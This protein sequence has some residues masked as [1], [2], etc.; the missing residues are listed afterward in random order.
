MP[1][2]S[3]YSRDPSDPVVRAYKAFMGSVAKQLGASSK[4]RDFVQQT[5]AFEKR[6]AQ[7]HVAAGSDVRSSPKA[8]YNNVTIEELQIIANKA[9]TM[10]YRAVMQRRLPPVGGRQPLGRFNML[11]IRN[12]SSSI[13]TNYQYQLSSMLGCAQLLIG[14]LCFVLQC[15]AN[16]SNN[17][18]SIGIWGGIIFFI[19]GVLCI[20]AGSA[21]TSC[22]IVSVNA[23]S[24]V[25]ILFAIILMKSVSHEVSSHK[26]GVQEVH[27]VL[28]IVGAVERIAAFTTTL[29]ACSSMCRHHAS[30]SGVVIAPP[31]TGVVGVN[32]DTMTIAP[33][34]PLGQMPVGVPYP[35]QQPAMPA[36]GAPPPGFQPQY[37]P[38]PAPMVST[39]PPP[40][41]TALPADPPPA[42]TAAVPSAPPA[43]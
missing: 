20:W 16:V 34:L 11:L 13:R 21:K 9:V 4:V 8:M 22:L 7:L 30:S 12:E 6:L 3:Y 41:Y 17:V 26:Q 39:K 29:I 35:D 33:V 27:I 31:T 38:Q 25:S 2:K 10:N 23:L 43:D 28:I 14:I 37:M 19:T 5:Y 36:Y 15:V 32:N 42:Y 40:Q 18:V 24:L 1:D